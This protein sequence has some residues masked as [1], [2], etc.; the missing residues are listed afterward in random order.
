MKQFWIAVTVVCVAAAGLAMWLRHYDAGF[1]I[2]TIG[3]LSWF[4]NY[5]VTAKELISESKKDADEEQ[6]D[7]VD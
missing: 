5:R 2:A 6:E 7:S 3:A 4:L 1:V